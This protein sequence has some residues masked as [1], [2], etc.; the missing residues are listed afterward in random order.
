MRKLLLLAAMLLLPALPALG[1]MSMLSSN[2][3][4][5]GIGHAIWTNTPD[6]T[7]PRVQS[8]NV[9]YI[10]LQDPDVHLFTSPRA[11]S[12]AFENNETRSLIVSNFVRNYGVKVATACNFY[13]GVGLPASNPADPTNENWACEIHGMLVCTGQVVS[14]PDT[15][16]RLASF[17]FDFNKNPTINYNNQDA[18]NAEGMHTVV[19]G[20]YPVLSNGVV[21]TAEWLNTNFPD[22]DIHRDDQPRTV[23]GLSQDNRWLFL[24]VI[25]GR[26]NPYYSYG[27]TD[28]DSALWMLQVGAW[29]AINMDGGGSAAMYKAD[30]AGYPMAL[31]HSSY[32]SAYPNQRRE[33]IIGNHFGV[34]AAELPSF[35]SGV[36]SVPG[37]TTAIIN[38]NTT[39]ESSSQVEYGTTTDY[40]AF[41]VMDSTP[42]T[43]HTILLTGL[44][45][46]TKY[47]YRVISGEESSSCAAPFTTTNPPS[48]I[49]FPL[50]NMWQYSIEKLDGAGWIYSYFDDQF[51]PSGPGVLWCDTYYPM[52]KPNIQFLPLSTK[53]PLNPATGKTYPTYYFRTHF[54]FPYPTEGMVLTFTNY[55]DDGAA[56]YLNGNLLTNMYLRIPAYNGDYATGY[57]CGGD[58]TCPVIFTLSGDQV[59]TNLIQG[60]NILAVEVH[61][62]QAS[63]YDVTFGCSLTYQDPRPVDFIYSL[64]AIPGRTNA[65]IAWATLSNATT[66]VFYGLDPDDYA[67]WTPLD[68]TPASIHTI[69]LSDLTPNTTYYYE[70]LST[71]G[72]SN[73]FASGSFTTLPIP[74]TPTRL[75]IT[76]DGNVITISWEGAA[77]TLQESDDLGNPNAWA[78]VLG[79][80]TSSPYCVTNPATTTFY[81]LR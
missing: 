50:V 25:D 18:A 8:V 30:C 17:L 38:W 43:D 71:L 63:S 81:R 65:T 39:T 44:T 51:W 57:P 56:W 34:Y 79:P 21:M 70:A 9:L 20:S 48:A 77:Y 58:A 67:F 22:N 75:S 4:F 32:V 29:D 59:R 3:L 15:S 37:G 13:T 24:M 27:A 19:T 41:S 26:Q 28:E 10:D 55:F 61:N 35:I 23:F 1:T 12:F 60:D 36:H 16:G 52:G 53:L 14:V 45:P 11:P 66:Q 6:A 68:S 40:G 80:I 5:K 74:V 78:D 54:N 72:S 31:S 69:A 7:I 46:G 64:A 42:V 62:Y 49:I 47:F 73:Y 33:R 76:T 2:V